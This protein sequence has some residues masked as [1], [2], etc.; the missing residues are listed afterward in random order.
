MRKEIFETNDSFPT[1]L[2]VSAVAIHINI[3]FESVGNEFVV[4]VYSD[5]FVLFF[6]IYFLYFFCP[7]CIP[8]FFFILTILF[9]PFRTLGVFFISLLLY[10]RRIKLCICAFPIDVYIYTYREQQLK[11]CKS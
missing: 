11:V 3:Y 2:C 1:S 4:F 9:S 10:F 8:R 7:L 6:L 5:I